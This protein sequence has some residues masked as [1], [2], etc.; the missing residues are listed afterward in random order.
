MKVKE[1]SG[2]EQEKSERCCRCA[3]GADVTD[4]NKRLREVDVDQ[5][6]SRRATGSTSRAESEDLWAEPAREPGSPKAMFCP[7]ATG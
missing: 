1:R 7:A 5:Y 3:G 2:G 6:S 4:D